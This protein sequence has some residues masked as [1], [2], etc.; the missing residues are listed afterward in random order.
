M[1]GGGIFAIF[2][3]ALL[4]SCTYLPMD[5]GPTSGVT[6]TESREAIVLRPS[7]GSAG[8]TGLIFYPG[9][10][11]DP[12]AYVAE[13]SGVAAAG[14]PVV[15]AKVTGNLAVLSIDA[16]LALRG[17]V[18]GVVQWVIGGHSLG[19]AMAAWSVYNHPEAYIG[20]VFLAAYP[21][22][23]TSLAAWPHP[24]LSLSASNDGLATPQK[25]SDSAPLLP[26]P[27]QTVADIGA[28]RAI[29]G[30]PLTV[31]HQIAGG[32]H[33]QFGSYGAQDGDGGATITPAEQHAEVVTFIT[34]FFQ[35]NGW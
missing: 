32:D 27:Q 16:G 28:Y 25:E 6:T 19:G 15:I 5:V 33:A 3:A 29:S 20:L 12:H 23:S 17:S 8:V 11:V 26:G 21:S 13:L 31:F 35:A 24:V 22:T 2:T 9:A 1:R 7:A 34:T 10:L 30:S 18:S 4:A 14:I